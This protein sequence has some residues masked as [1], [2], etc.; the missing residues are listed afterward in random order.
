METAGCKERVYDWEK[1]IF[2]LLGWVL[3][4]GAGKD[5]AASPK[6]DCRSVR[7]AQQARTGGAKAGKRERNG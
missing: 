6:K 2:A 4:M 3:G 7:L 5:D 1:C